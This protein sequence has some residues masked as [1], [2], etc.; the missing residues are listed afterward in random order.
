[1][2]GA[3]SEDCLLVYITAPTDDA[4]RTLCEVLV[5][6]RLAACANIVDNVSSLYWW[7]GSMERAREC[8]CVLK[9]VRSRY[10]ELEA[11]VKAIHEYEVPCVVAIPIVAGNPDFLDWIRTETQPVTTV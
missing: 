10:T 9:T 5:Q 6:E 1:M 7:Q 3:M 11:R 4:A 2:N 8:V